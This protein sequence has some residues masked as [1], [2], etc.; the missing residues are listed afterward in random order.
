L[1]ENGSRV[2]KE[3]ASLGLDTGQSTTHIIPVIIGGEKETLAA[4][5]ELFEKGLFIPA[6]RPPTVAPGTS[7]LRISLQSE[8]TGEHL[9]RLTEAM[10]ELVTCGL[11]PSR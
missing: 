6:I 2:R 9:D 1:K 10:Q 5:A 4:S 3:L 11:L 8:H 7:R